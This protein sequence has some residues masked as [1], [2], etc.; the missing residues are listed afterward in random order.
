MKKIFLT[1]L[2]LTSLKAFS[3]TSYYSTPIKSN[4]YVAPVDLSL[5]ERVNRSKQDNYLRNENNLREQ[6][7]TVR[8]LLNYVKGNN[9]ILLTNDYN[10]AVQMF[11]NNDLGDNNIVRIIKSNLDNIEYWIDYLYSNPNAILKTK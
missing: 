2:F 4:G 11:N 5:L 6:L 10:E 8:K 9:K 1:I 3:Q 7:K